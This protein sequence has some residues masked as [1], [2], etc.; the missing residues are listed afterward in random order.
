MATRSANQQST[1][2]NDGPVPATCA[3]DRK[4]RRTSKDDKIAGNELSHLG[5][6]AE[7][8]EIPKASLQ[9]PAHRSFTAFLT[10]MPNVG[11]DSDFAR[12]Q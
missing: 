1:T 9:K 8:R 7:H 11:E 12:A 5:D 2:K 10:S 3:Q 4:L 6:E